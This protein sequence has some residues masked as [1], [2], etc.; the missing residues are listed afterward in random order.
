MTVKRGIFQRLVGALAPIAH[1]VVWQPERGNYPRLLTLDARDLAGR[2][3]LY[4]LWHLGVRPQWLRVAYAADLAVAMSMLAE[5]AE[6]TAFSPHD[7]PFVSWCF[8][9][10]AEASGRVRFLAAL[11][12]PVVQDVALTCDVLA[13]PLATA[14]PCALPANGNAMPSP[15]RR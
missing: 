14:I 12:S 11:L 10:V 13:D 8:C 4:A 7:G 6:I 9:P 5:T 1:D 3:G 15:A 2:S